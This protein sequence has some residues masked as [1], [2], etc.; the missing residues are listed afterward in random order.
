MTKGTNT[1]LVRTA[2]LA[3]LYVALTLSFSAFSYGPIQFRISEVLVLLPLWNKRWAPGVV[4]GTIIANFFS[5]L[6][7][8][9]VVFGSGATIVALGFMVFIAAV[10]GRGVA[11]LAP[12]L[13]NALI[14]AAELNIVYGVN[15]IESAWYVGLSEFIIVTIGLFI[16]KAMEKQPH[17]RAIMEAS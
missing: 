12:I 11:L 1:W 7:L 8:I 16:L 4:I 5:P 3:A 13:I 9:D 6:G 10:A 17:I 15:Y 2:L 14:I